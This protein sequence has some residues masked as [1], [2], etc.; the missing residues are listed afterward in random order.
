MPTL[1]P[2]FYLSHVRS[3][4]KELWPGPPLCVSYEVS[5]P[6]YRDS[7]ALRHR[8][9]DLIERGT[10]AVSPPGSQNTGTNPLPAYAVGPSK[11]Y[12][13]CDFNRR[14]L[15]GSVKTYWPSKDP[16]SSSFHEKT[17]PYGCTRGLFSL[18]LIHSPSGPAPTGPQSLILNMAC[19]T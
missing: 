14:I 12:S 5:G 8:V 11:T 4:S 3:A 17:C 7:W 2:G 1:S 9:R 15:Y 19:L 10:I 16:I 18:K 13:K 6:R